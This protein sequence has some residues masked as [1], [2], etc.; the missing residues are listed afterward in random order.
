MLADNIKY[1]RKKKQ[2]S[3]Q[4]LAEALDIPRTTLGDYERGHTEPNIETLVRL[5]KYF[6]VDIDALLTSKMSYQ[7]YE[8]IN[9][10][11]QKVLAI[12]VDADNQQNIE[13]VG[14][15]ARAGYLASYQDPEYIKDLPKLYF[16]MIKEGTYR[17]FEIEGDSMLPMMPGSVVVC[18]YVERLED[19]KNNKTYIIATHLDGVVYKRILLNPDQ[20]SLTAVSDNPIYP[21]YKIS[22]RDIAE[23][24]QYYAHL[25]FSDVKVS[26][27]YV[28]E[29]KLSD[30]Q[31]KVT[32]IKELLDEGDQN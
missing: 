6:D 25:S 29:E 11:E 26:L 28:Q 8:I 15:K 27:D 30:I 10:D 2:L 21:P 19:L 31:E 18:S 20:K 5:A 9:T 13:L 14:A 22:Y 32:Y 24:W 7:E 17:A 3:Q 12:T 16:P 1:L 4:Q 23:I